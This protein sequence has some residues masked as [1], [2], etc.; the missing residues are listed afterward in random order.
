MV[1]NFLDK[2][3]VGAAVKN[4]FMQNKELGEDYTN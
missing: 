1:Y 4:E 2:K 3:A